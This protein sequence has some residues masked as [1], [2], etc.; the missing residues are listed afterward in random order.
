MNMKL[1]DS[2]NKEKT[3]TE[4]LEWVALISVSAILILRL[5]AALW[6]Q[7]VISYDDK[8]Y[9]G[10]AI[11]LN[12]KTTIKDAVTDLFLPTI[13]RIGF[14]T[15]GYNSW[16]LLALKLFKKYVNRERVFQLLNCL[17]FLAQVA[18]IAALASRAHKRNWFIYSVSFLYLS[19]PIIFGINR[20]VM[21]ENLV[22]AALFVFSAMALVLINSGKAEG[23]RPV[24]PIITEILI[25]AVCAFAMGVCCNLREYALP[26]LLLGAIGVVIVLKKERRYLALAIFLV[27]IAPY[28]L[29]ALKV[30]S[31]IASETI[32]KSG[33]VK[34][35]VDQHVKGYRTGWIEW[36]RNISFRTMGVPIIAFLVA[37]NT[38]LFHG[39]AG[40]IAGS[41]RS[42]GLLKTLSAAKRSFTERDK[43]L[44]ILFFPTV[45]M[46][47]FIVCFSTFR[48]MRIILTPFVMNIILI[49]LGVKALGIGKYIDRYS[50]PVMKTFLGLIVVSW[51]VF[52]FQLFFA[53]GGGKDYAV[54]RKGPPTYNH[55]MFLRKIEKFEDWHVKE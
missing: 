25:P 24:H 34:T 27:I 17:F 50:S 47:W 29:S 9:R 16:N 30:L 7:P 23:S 28:F 14:R 55:P 18:G 32:A 51:A 19:S 15:Y 35:N 46:Y 4:I 8:H 41:L 54:T 6:T 11:Y 37:G 3:L 44:F 22:P 2:I 52:I 13:K 38:M 48:D 33:I 1:P 12:E 40:R 21:T 20:W 49:L 42:R 5:F 53:F 31:V 43:V 36:F 26:F 39:A 45:F 10:I